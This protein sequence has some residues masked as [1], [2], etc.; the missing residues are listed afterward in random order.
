MKSRIR[1]ALPEDF[2]D[3][4]GVLIQIAHL[5]DETNSAPRINRG[6]ARSIISASHLIAHLAFLLWKMVWDRNFWIVEGDVFIR[7]A[8]DD[9]FVG[10]QTIQNELHQYLDMFDDWRTATLLSNLS[11]TDDPEAITNAIEVIAK[12]AEATAPSGQSLADTFTAWA[13]RFARVSAFSIQLPL[14]VAGARVVHMPPSS[15]ILPT[16]KPRGAHGV[17]SELPGAKIKAIA[18]AIRLR[19]ADGSDYLCSRDGE[20]AESMRGRLIYFD[21]RPG[22][23]IKPWIRASKMP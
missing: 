18:E 3:R 17:L 23:M 16:L 10:S 9:L 6:E 15:R 2:D 20:D 7:L 1:H 22:S 13:K 19:S 4:H 12:T 21:R 14:G 11:T 5:P 8:G